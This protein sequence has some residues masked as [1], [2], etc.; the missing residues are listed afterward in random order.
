MLLDTDTADEMVG[1]AADAVAS[2]PD[3]FFQILDRLPAPIYVTDTE[4]TITYFNEA[5][6]KLA[7]RTPE[8]GRD[9]L[10]VTWKIYTSEGE[11][12]PH[13]ECPM[14][15][16]IREKR[17]VRNVE[18]VAERPDG[19]RI[20]F[21]PYPTPY[22]D[23]DGNMIGAVNLLLD[24]TPNKRS[25][26]LRAQADKCRRLGYTID[27]TSAAETLLLMAAKYDEQ[28]LKLTLPSE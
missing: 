21:A 9:K 15:V 1:S 4:G 27:D 25:V 26:Y 19:T 5:C 24:V 7:G 23:A 14:A 17:S 10:C 13:H 8:I 20:A 22:Y 12:V 16:A 18:A 11:F 28:A 3:T 2:Q 6:V